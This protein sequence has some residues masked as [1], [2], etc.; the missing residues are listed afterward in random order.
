MVPAK[1]AAHDRKIKYLVVH[2]TATPQTTTIESIQ[3]HWSKVLGWKNPGYHYIVKPNGE[4]V[5]LQPENLASNGVADYN[6]PSIHISYIGGVDAAGKAVDNRTV[7]QRNSLAIA[8]HILK[9]R[10]PDAIIQGHRD[11]PKVAK[12]CPCFPAKLEYASI[13]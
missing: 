13:K 5:N 12:D 10:Y 6:T 3:N 11:F 2:C 1:I 9:Q 8:L 4:I 7:A